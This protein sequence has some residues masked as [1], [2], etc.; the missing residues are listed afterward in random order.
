MKSVSGVGVTPGVELCEPSQVGDTVH[1]LSEGKIRTYE[2]GQN[3]LS[4]AMRPELE[5]V[6]R[7]LSL[8]VKG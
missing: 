7:P 1:V 8:R 5:T 2:D 6:C 4:E 3:I